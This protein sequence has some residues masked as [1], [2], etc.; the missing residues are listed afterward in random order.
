MKRFEIPVDKD[1][2]IQ[3]W[4]LES[5][6]E[7]FQLTDKNRKQLQGWLVWVPETKGEEDSRKFIQRCLKEYEEQTGLELGIWY[8]DKLIGCIGLHDI[9]K[10]SRRASIGYWLA[11]EYQGKGIMTKA[12]R[13][14]INFG[15][16]KLD[17]N[18]I[19]LGAG[20]EN[21]KSRA[22]AERLGFTQE[23]TL[24]KYEFIDGRFV[25][26]VVYSIL[27]EEWKG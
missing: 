15:F 1:L 6:A 16:K 12:V 23:G 10:N 11:A 8:K 26:H 19:G 22:I 14:L 3:S 9:N 20:K 18:R 7:L 24:R 13:N 5:A 27:Q 2:V 21:L 25:D 4:K 17:L